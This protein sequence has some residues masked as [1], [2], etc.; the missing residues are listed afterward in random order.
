MQTVE[1]AARIEAPADRAWAFVGDFGGDVLTQGYVERVEP[2]GH[3]VGA[4]RIYHLAA[5]IGGDRV[6]ER[7]ERLDDRDRVIEYSMVDNGPLLWAGYAGHIAVTPA[8]PDA[9]IVHVRTRFLPIEPAAHD[10]AAM[11]RANIGKYI[12]NLAEAVRG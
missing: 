11:S 10:Y 4:I 12:A 9:C 2:R 8:G 7:L 1:V 6:I 3:G 5:E